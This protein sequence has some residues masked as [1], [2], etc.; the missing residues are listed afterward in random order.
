MISNRLA[1]VVT[2]V[3]VFSAV[4]ADAGSAFATVILPRNV[5]LDIPTNWTVMSDSKRTTLAA[6]KESVLEARRLSDVENEMPFSANYDEDGITVAS[7]AVRYYPSMDTTEMEADLGGATFVEALDKGVRETFVSGLETGGGNVGV[8]DGDKETIDKWFSIL[9]DREP[10]Q[11]SP[12]R[13]FSIR[14]YIEI[15]LGTAHQCI[16]IVHDNTRLSRGSGLVLATYMRQDHQLYCNWTVGQAT[17][18][19]WPAFGRE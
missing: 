4:H 1:I 19:T 3:L 2:S 13:W 12:K 10:I 14:K 7:I 15:G 8:M 18:L 11:T 9:C 6:W 5:S 16:K 17:Q